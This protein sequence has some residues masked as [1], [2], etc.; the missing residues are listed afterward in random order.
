MKLKKLMYYQ[1]NAN[2]WIEIVYV[3]LD[4][5]FSLTHY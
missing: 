4:N 1:A 2:K 3:S 5:I